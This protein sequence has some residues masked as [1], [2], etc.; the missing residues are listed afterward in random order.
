[1][2]I[3][4]KYHLLLLIKSLLST[5]N[6]SAI[7]ERVTRSGCET[8]VH[9]LETVDGS[10]PN[11]FANHLPVLFFSTRTILSR[12]ISFILVI[13]LNLLQ[14]YWFIWIKGNKLSFFNCY[15]WIA[16]LRR[17]I[18]PRQGKAF[19]VTRKVSS[20]SIHTLL[21][22]DEHKNP[23]EVGLRKNGFRP[24]HEAVRYALSFG[25]KAEIPRLLFR[26][27]KRQL[28]VKTMQAIF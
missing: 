8:L 12:F 28:P 21:C 3:R 1:M 4:T 2:I 13:L 26:V 19:G 20:N 25:C 11:S 17:A 24:L 18:A 7:L 23:T 14:I 16:R 22:S 9:H 6:S 5:F 27:L 15:L 10:L